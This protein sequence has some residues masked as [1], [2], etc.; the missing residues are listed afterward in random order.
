MVLMEHIRMEDFNG[1]AASL[2]AGVSDVRGCLILSRDG[3]VSDRTRPTARR[4]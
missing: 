2:A 1:L 4:R 3:L